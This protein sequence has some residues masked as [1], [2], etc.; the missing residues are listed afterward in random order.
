[1][2]LEF[3]VSPKHCDLSIV[4]TRCKEPTAGRETLREH[5]HMQELEKDNRVTNILCI[6]MYKQKREIN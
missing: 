5:G 1:M 6:Y 2:Y 3:A 4:I